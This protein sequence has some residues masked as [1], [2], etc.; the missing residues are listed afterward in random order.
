M[1]NVDIFKQQKVRFLVVFFL[2]V[3]RLSFLLSMQVL[4]YSAW[5]CVSFTY[6]T[7]VMEA[8]M[9]FLKYF[10]TR[11]KFST[12]WFSFLIRTSLVTGCVFIRV[13]LVDVVSGVT[14]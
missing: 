3:S 7:F 5:R 8:G 14:L 1:L 11:M 2:W 10:A 6:F 9:D 4:N 13:F 12:R